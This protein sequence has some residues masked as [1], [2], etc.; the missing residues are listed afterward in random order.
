[1]LTI[2]YAI[3][4]HNEDESL[5]KLLELIINYKDD[6]DEIVIL[7]DYSENPQTSKIIKKYQ[8]YHSVKFHQRH[9]KRNFALQ[10]NYLSKIC[11][12]DYIFNID[13]DEIPASFLI[14]NIKDIINNYPQIE[15]FW[16]PRINIVA[17]I[18]EKH[19]QAWQWKINEQGWV[20]FPDYQ[21]RIYKNNPRIRW[22]NSV[23]EVLNGYQKDNFL[24]AEKDYALLH[25][26]K[27]NQQEKQN[28]FYN[29]LT[30]WLSKFKQLVR[31]K[32]KI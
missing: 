32:I 15:V 18:T 23:H 13:A 8:K 21:G 1:M 26:K 19:L 24:P 4:T 31:Q 25:Y 10:K 30:P 29:N 11:K 20:N 28:K 12:N 22:K 7:D 14:K 5:A 9:L 3:L 2:S 16:L 17:G 27:I 6:L